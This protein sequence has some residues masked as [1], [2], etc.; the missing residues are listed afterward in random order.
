MSF[1]R[2]EVYQVK[3]GNGLR[4]LFIYSQFIIVIWQTYT[5]AQTCL[6]KFWAKYVDVDRYIWNLSLVTWSYFPTR[7][8]LKLCNPELWLTVKEL[9]SEKC[10]YL[11]Q[12]RN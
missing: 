6:P 2:R 1:F 8:T 7:L 9:K 3:S 11:K 12:G 5:T 10:K 4:E